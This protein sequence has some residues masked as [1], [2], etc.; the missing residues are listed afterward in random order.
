M[1]CCDRIALMKGGK[2]VAMGSPQEILAG[3]T[4][5]DLDDEEAKVCEV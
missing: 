5:E 2:V 1:A 4:Q 3:M